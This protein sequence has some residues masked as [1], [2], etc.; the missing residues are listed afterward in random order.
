[1]AETKREAPEEVAWNVER[2]GPAWW[3]WLDE[4]ATPTCKRN[5]FEPFRFLDQENKS[6][7]L[8]T[9]TVLPDWWRLNSQSRW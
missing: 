9:P 5:A 7:G 3:E 4:I 6:R 8:G 2:D 1:M